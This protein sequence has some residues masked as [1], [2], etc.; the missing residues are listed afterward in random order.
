MNLYIVQAEYSWGEDKEAMR[1]AQLDLLQSL[2]L[3]EFEERQVLANAEQC[4]QL[5]LGGYCSKY[6][7]ESLKGEVKHASISDNKQSQVAELFEKL[8]DKFTA[9]LE[10][11]FNDKCRQEQPGLALH[12][13]QQTMLAEDCCTDA[14]QEHLAN[15]WRILAIQPQPDQRRPD[16]I[17]GRNIP[18]LPISAV[19][20]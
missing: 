3:V 8:T 19:R 7:A 9:T 2:G 15:G 14:L 1:Q 17:L 10:R 20:G 13:V 6:V 4:L 18:P 12:N 16:Y 11:Q 5:V